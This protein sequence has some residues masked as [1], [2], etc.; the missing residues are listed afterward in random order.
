MPAPTL[1]NH[2]S[3]KSLCDSFSCHFKNKISQIRSAF[4][5]HI[6]NPVQLDTP[7]VN[8]PLASF[9]P[10]TVDEVRKIIMSSPNKSCDL[11]P[12]SITLLNACFDTL[13]YPN[14]VNA[15]L[16]FGLFPGDFKQMKVNPL[17]RKS[18]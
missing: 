8:S 13:L 18:T 11:A 4:P 2:V 10:A 17:F 12:L 1:P 6:L 16:C 5:D 9:K 14:I 7:Q 3:I 15:S